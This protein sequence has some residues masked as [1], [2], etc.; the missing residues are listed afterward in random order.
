MALPHVGSVTGAAVTRAV[1]PQQKFGKVLEKKLTPKPPAGVS[2]EVA[3]KPVVAGRPGRVEAGQ[4]RA[5]ARV[6][7]AAKPSSAVRVVDQLTA[8]QQRLDKILAMAESGRS[9]TPAELIGMQARVSQASQQL[10]LAGKVVDKATSGMKQ[11]LQT[12]V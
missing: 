6:D 10:D 8:A 7:S 9:F 3:P 5:G 2:G 11:I 1:E 12:Q 4:V